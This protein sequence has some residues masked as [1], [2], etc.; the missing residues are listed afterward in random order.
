M[1]QGEA[2]LIFDRKW[3]GPLW[4]AFKALFSKL[5]ELHFKLSL[6]AEKRIKNEYF[7]KL[8]RVS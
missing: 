4:N 5:Y 2:D 7:R 1:I 3:Q 6:S 8:I